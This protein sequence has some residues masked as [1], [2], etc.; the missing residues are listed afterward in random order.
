MS[1]PTWSDVYTPEELAAALDFAAARVAKMQGAYHLAAELKAAAE[2][3]RDLAE[4]AETREDKR[5]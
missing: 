2:C 1:T 5:Q 3:I 4:R